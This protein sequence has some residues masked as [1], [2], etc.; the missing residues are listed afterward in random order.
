MMNIRKAAWMPEKSVLN[1]QI[2]IAPGLPPF[3]IKLSKS[4]SN[5]F[6]D[7]LIVRG[8]WASI[9]NNKHPLF[10]NKT[11]KNWRRDDGSD[12]QNVFSAGQGVTVDNFAFNDSTDFW[13][14]FSHLE[15]IGSFRNIID[16]D[17]R[18][19][20]LTTTQFRFIVKHENSEISQRL[21][22]HLKLHTEIAEK[23]RLIASFGFGPGEIKSIYVHCFELIDLVMQ[24]RESLQL[25]KI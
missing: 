10:I 19:L 7:P 25:R 22:A 2:G 18:L 24:K 5:D 23:N 13:S 17:E 6:V 4:T 21:M 12:Q 14:S 8:P 1:T 15:I 16:N 9:P 11:A 3:V 20:M